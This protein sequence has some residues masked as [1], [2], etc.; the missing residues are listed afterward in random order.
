MQGKDTCI[1]CTEDIK[2]SVLFTCGHSVCYINLHKQLL[3]N[4]SRLNAI[5]SAE[6]P[7]VLTCLICNE[8][9]A[10]I[11]KSTILEL[12]KIERY[13]NF[14][15]G[16]GKKLNSNSSSSKNFCERHPKDEVVFKCLTC[17]TFICQL[18][19]NFFHSQHTF[20]NLN[21]YFQN[22]RDEIAKIKMPYLKLE[23]IAETL[24]LEENKIF[25]E[26]GIKTINLTDYIQGFIIQ[27]R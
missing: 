2:G 3:F 6:K 25:E 18:C 8:G 12:L 13:D 23:E 11:T 4:Y 26:I 20:Q 5:T 16:I 10:E 27:I 9:T 17:N 22:L 14:T 15:D 1:T 7:I 21:K 24:N 19:K